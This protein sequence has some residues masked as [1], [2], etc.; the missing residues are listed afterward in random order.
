MALKSKVPTAH[1]FSAKGGFGAVIPKE[2]SIK[3]SE[4]E[5]AFHRTHQ[6]IVYPVGQ[7]FVKLFVFTV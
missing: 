5:K 1:Q 6:I 7:I 3:F 2:E 4:I